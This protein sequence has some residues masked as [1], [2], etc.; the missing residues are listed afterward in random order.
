M[1]KFL[2]SFFLVFS[3]YAA[4]KNISIA[5]VDS[6]FGG[7][8]TAKAIEGRAF[9]LSQ[10]H[11]AHFKINHYGDTL[12]A[13]Y[14]E[15]TADQIAFHA[16][17]TIMKAHQDGA[18]YVF[19]ACNTASAQF[20]KIRAILLKD[21]KTAPMANTTYSIIQSS[22]DDLKDK[23][24]KH[25]VTS[26]RINIA[27]LATPATLKADVYPR[28][29]QKAFG[30]KE[31]K[32]SKN[33]FTTVPRWYQKNSKTAENAM[34]VVEF[35][36]N[37]KTVAIFQIAPANWVEMIEHQA[38]E[39]EKKTA[40]SIDLKNLTKTIDTNVKF[41]VVAHF[42]THFPVFHQK[43]VAALTVQKRV[44]PK[45]IYIQ[46]GELFASKFQEMMDESLKE[47]K[48][49]QKLTTVEVKKLQDDLEPTIFISGENQAETANLVK[50]IFPEQ[51]KTEIKTYQP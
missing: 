11:P 5:T 35:E 16:S 36:T 28:E 7:F 9:V 37:K 10:E 31:I 50:T 29:L 24:Q 26:D 20:E 17:Q 39:A 34:S 22:V 38:S 23:I 3:A 6:G 46:Q 18:Q 51:K 12:N 32:A 33:T 49:A 40:T 44:D 14:G 41:D 2:L 13:P 27:I 4:D 47:Q 45:T 19:L 21:K 30:V 42:C 43:V 48:R 1:F 8:F 15:K 25:F